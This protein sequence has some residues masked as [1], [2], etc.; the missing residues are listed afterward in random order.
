VL[1]DLKARGLTVAPE[2]AV[3][4]GALGFWAAR[5]E[6]FP[7]TRKPRCWVHKS[8][9]VLNCWPLS[10]Q[11]KAKKALH[12]IWMAQ[13]RS[14]AEKAL[15]PFIETYQAKYPKA[16]P[17]L[18]KDREPLLTFY[19]FPAE[20]WV[21]LLTEIGF[22]ETDRQHQGFSIYPPSTFL[23]WRIPIRRHGSSNQLDKSH[24]RTISITIARL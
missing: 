5:E 7:S 23:F 6:V 18:A 22:G 1:L 15:D 4:E 13:S 14:G 24:G 21:H 10:V 11:P 17:C 2:L 16:V 8:A 19:A 12:E 9:N 3:G 20:H